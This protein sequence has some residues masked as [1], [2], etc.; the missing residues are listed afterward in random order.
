MVKLK[1]QF[2]TGGEDGC[3]KRSP[4]VHLQTDLAEGFFSPGSPENSG[5]CD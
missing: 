3:L 1:G 2:V 4:K 5:F